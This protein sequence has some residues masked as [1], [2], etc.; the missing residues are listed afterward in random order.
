MKKVSSNPLE[1]KPI[2]QESFRLSSPLEEALKALDMRIELIQALIPL[3]LEAVSEELQNEVSRLAGPKNSRKGDKT[4]NRRWGSQ[5]GS[6]YLSDQKLPISVPRVRDVE[7]NE[8]VSLDVYH[9]FQSPRRMDEG[10]LLRML[11]GISTRSYEACAETIPEA[12]GLSSSTVSSRFIKASAEK[13]RQFQERS[14]ANYDLVALFLDGK[15]FADQEMIIALGVTIDGQKIPLGFV[16]TVSENE[17]VCRQFI[18]SL[19]DRG[20]QYHQGLLCL[21]DGSKGLYSALR[22][23]LDGYVAI[24]RCQWHKRENVIAYLPKGEQE[25]FKKAMQDAY[26]QETYKSAKAALNAL[27]PSLALM[28]ESALNSLEEGFEETLTIHRLGLMPQLK[29]SFRTT[30]CIESLNSMV[31]QL[32]RNVKRWKNSNQRNRWLGTALLDIEPRLRK[33]KGYRFLTE[34]RLALQKELKLQ[35]DGQY[36]QEL[37]AD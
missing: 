17:R 20:L 32:T 9:Q 19:I 3:G 28:N 14:L 1:V 25:D 24:Q 12:F 16:Q 2:D 4:A 35:P 27:K 8:E 31:A 5:Q 37:A 6:V 7:K 11:K 10:L 22:K 36:H 23:A 15:S 34:L 26:D 13:L 33:I 18:D 30:N 21:I 29:L